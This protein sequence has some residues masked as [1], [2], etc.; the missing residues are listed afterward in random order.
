MNDPQQPVRIANEIGKSK[1]LVC[2]YEFDPRKQEFRYRFFRRGRLVGSTKDARRVV[3][4]M[5]RYATCSN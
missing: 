3:T 2:R 4:Q 5:E 1:Q